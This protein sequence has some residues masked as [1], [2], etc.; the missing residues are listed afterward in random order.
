MV[1]LRISQYQGESAQHNF[2]EHF[3]IPSAI[4]IPSSTDVLVKDLFNYAAENATP[5]PLS[6]FRENI[7]G[8]RNVVGII[9][10]AGIGKTVLCK[11][12]LAKVLKTGLFEAEYFFYLQFRRVNYQDQTNFFSFLNVSLPFF[13]DKSRRQAVL[14]ELGKSNHVVMIFDGLDE[15]IINPSTPCPKIS[16]D[17][18]AHPEIF[19]KNLLNG[20]ILPQSKKIFTSRPKELLELHPSLRPDFIVKIIGLDRKAQKQICKDICGNKANTIFD[21]VMRQ[22]LFESL[23]LVPTYY[24]LI[25]HAM[26]NFTQSSE[27]SFFPLKNTLTGPLAMAVCLCAASPHMRDQLEADFEK[28]AFLALEGL[29]RHKFIFS[30]TDLKRIALNLDER[31]FF[32][33]VS[34]K[35]SPNLLVSDDSKRVYFAHLIIQEFFAALM[36][37]FFSSLQDFRKFFLGVYLGPIRTSK[38]DFDLSDYRWEVVAKFLFGLCNTTIAKFLLEKFP[39]LTHSNL[40][41][42]RNVLCNFVLRSFPSN[43][44]PEVD[45]FQRVLRFCSWANELQDDKFAARIASRLKN[46]LMVVGEILPSDVDPIHYTLRQRE[47][48]LHLDTTHFDTCFLGTSL[49]R[50]LKELPQTIAANI[51]VSCI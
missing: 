29:K 7:S 40:S 34:L 33:V 45:Y 51:S 43:N 19:I 28:L 24:I 23:C 14:A 13:H 15:A 26:V 12:I 50:F 22:P 9:G 42:R 48:P 8:F 2:S 18:D 36:L 49:E 35:A 31:F 32:L 38:P 27:D 46:K 4:P 11:Q 47:K 25:M 17:Q 6:S 30:E 16:L 20:S 21:Y 37:I 44:L 41:N 39:S 3:H 1:P 5:S 10:S